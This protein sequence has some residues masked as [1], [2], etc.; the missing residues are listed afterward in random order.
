AGRVGRRTATSETH[1]ARSGRPPGKV[2]GPPGDV[3]DPHPTR[4]EKEPV[5]RI[6]LAAPLLAAAALFGGIRSAAA[7][8]C[9]ADGYGCCP[10]PCC[11]AQSCFPTCQ[12]ECKPS[13]KLVWDTV[14]EKRWHTCYHTVHE[15]VMKP[16]C[17]T[18]Y[19]EE[20]KTCYKTC[21]E[22]CYHEVCETVC[23]PCQ[24]TCYKEVCETVCKPC[25]ETC[26][27]PVCYT[28]CKKV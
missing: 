14:M 25:Y 19:R 27:K 8:H 10:E 5:M 12:Q 13:Y 11:D 23:K 3:N 26:Y 16:V 20:C 6:R 9:G 24:K 18:C 22:T 21:H 15:T 4:V 2:S 28:V 17:K 1:H 7:S